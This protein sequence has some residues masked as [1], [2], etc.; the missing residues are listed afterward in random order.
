MTATRL[1][2]TILQLREELLQ[3]KLATR[4]VQGELERTNERIRELTTNAGGVMRYVILRQLADL[5]AVA[6]CWPIASI[7]QAALWVVEV[8]D[9]QKAELFAAE[10]FPATPWIVLPYDEAASVVRQTVAHIKRS[11]GRAA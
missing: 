2:A 8:A 4:K 3:A 6:A 10:R 1:R 11:A 9:Q 5:E 7:E